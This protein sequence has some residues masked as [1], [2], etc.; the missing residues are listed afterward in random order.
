MFRLRSSPLA[1]TV[2]SRSLATEA[3]AVVGDRIALTLAAPYQTFHTGKHVGLVTLPGAMG[4]FGI[5]AGHTPV[6][7]ELKPGVVSVYDNLGDSEPLEKWFVSG[8][9]VVL[10]PSNKASVMAVEC[11]KLDQLD[12][13]AV[14]SGIASSKSQLDASAPESVERAKAQISLETYEAMQSAMGLSA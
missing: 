13:E 8:G 5:T 11:V 6:I 4:E 1:R 10:E 9:F 7:S 2:I 3:S 14:K 12:G